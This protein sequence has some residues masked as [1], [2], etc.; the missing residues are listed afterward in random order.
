MRGQERHRLLPVPQAHVEEAASVACAAQGVKALAYHAGMSKD[1]RDANQN[2]FMTEPYTVMVAT[3][4]FGMGIDKTDVRYVFHTDLPASLE[5][6]YQEIGRAGRDGEPAEAHMLFGQGDIRM[7]RMF[8]DQEESNEERKRREH[9]RLGCATSPAATRPFAGA[10]APQLFRRRD[11]RHAAIAMRC[12]EPGPNCSDATPEARQILHIVERTGERYGATHIVDVLR[13]AET[14]KIVRERAPAR[15]HAFGSRR[16]A[17]KTNGALPLILHPARIKRIF[18]HHDV[19]GFA[20]GLSLT[21]DGRALPRER[22]AT[23]PQGCGA[24][25]HAQG[26][27]LYRSASGLSEE[28]AAC[29]LRSRNCVLPRGTPAIFVRPYLIF[30]DKTPDRNARSR[31]RSLREFAM[32]SGVGTS[33]LRDFGLWRSWMPSPLMASV[34]KVRRSPSLELEAHPATSD[35]RALSIAWGELAEKGNF[36][37]ANPLD[38]GSGFRRDHVE[39][40]SGNWRSRQCLGRQAQSRPLPGRVPCRGYWRLRRWT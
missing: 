19:A 26:P 5:S 7:R 29:W 36:R 17:R 14:E 32:V 20:A 1:S 40:Y 33:K 10:A 22:K 39:A 18:L 25:R 8:I 34:S 30:S 6:Y 24:Q 16:C 31:P 13:G 37:S 23:L 12:A 15:L 4:A 38:K 35:Q 28:Q 21:E 3:I 11:D 2:A 27:V 9:Q